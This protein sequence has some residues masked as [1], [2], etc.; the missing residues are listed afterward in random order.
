MKKFLN[1]FFVV[2]GVIFFFILIA[3]A[4]F[5]FADPFG[6]RK[7]VE[8]RPAPD[9]TIVEVN[10]TAD[11]L[12]TTSAESVPSSGNKLTPGQA[13][14]LELVG[15]DADAIPSEF[16]PSEEACFVR[17]FGQ[18]RVDEIVAGATP[19]VNEVLTG[20]GCLE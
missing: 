5:W 4:Y 3:L 1:I 16:S 13:N 10:Q 14:A 7:Y 2:L 20:Q 9:I 11:E 18:A 17:L 8:S 19:T 12:S 15:I 6:I